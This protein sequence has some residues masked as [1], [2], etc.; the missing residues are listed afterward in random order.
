MEKMENESGLTVTADKVLV[1]PHKVE[2]K[3]VGGIVIPAMTTQREELAQIT[4]VVLA[5]GQTCKL[6]DANGHALI[7]EVE[8]IEVG[9]TVL[10]AR[11]AGDEFPIGGVKYRIMRAAQI[12]AKAERP[13]DSVLRGAQSSVETFGANESVAAE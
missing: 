13:L 12:V 2:E 9:D 8:G 4:G 3:S 6:T 11:Y 7:P 5:M 1:R 10:Y